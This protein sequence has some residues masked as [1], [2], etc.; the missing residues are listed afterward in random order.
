[1]SDDEHLRAIA[2]ARDAGFT[3][4]HLRD[5]VGVT[6]IHAERHSSRGVVDTI[7]LRARAEAVAARYRADDYQRA[8]DPL[9]QR[10]G[11][12]VAVIT[13][14]LALP[15]HGEAGAPMRSQR[16]ASALWLPNTTHA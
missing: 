16:A 14:L 8:G 1:M 2:R 15:A 10:T 3:F 7:T 6:A 9:W 13:E 4:L 11:T 5:G 12:V